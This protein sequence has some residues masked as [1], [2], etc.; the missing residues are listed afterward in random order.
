MLKR[1]AIGVVEFPYPFRLFWIDFCLYNLIQKK[2]LHDDRSSLIL[3]ITAE[4]SSYEYTD[5][6]MQE[7]S[8]LVDDS[9]PAKK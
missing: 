4:G 2:Q 5:R 6:F 9:I 1:W 8:K 3:R 7:I